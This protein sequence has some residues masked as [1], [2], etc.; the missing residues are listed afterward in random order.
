MYRKKGVR[1]TLDPLCLWNT[2]SLSLLLDFDHTWLFLDPSG[3][4]IFPVHFSWLHKR[5]YRSPKFPRISCA[6]NAQ[7]IEV[8][9]DRFSTHG[10]Y[11]I[12]LCSICYPVNWWPCLLVFSF[13]PISFPHY[14]LISGVMNLDCPGADLI[15]LDL[16][17]AWS[18]K[19][20]VYIFSQAQHI[21]FM[22]SMFV[23][24]FKPL[25]C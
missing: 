16:I 19:T 21:S 10:K 9:F 1:P 17:G 23:S 14:F 24:V 5:P 6:R 22:S 15:F 13:Q 20:S 18:F 7:A 8:L 2:C 11:S 4:Y 12:P 25:Y 3:L